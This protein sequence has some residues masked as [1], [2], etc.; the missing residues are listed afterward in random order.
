MVELYIEQ[1]ERTEDVFVS[2]RLKRTDLS[3][4]QQAWTE[5]QM[6]AASV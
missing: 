4:N 6:E 1:N 3:K 2:K 5:Q